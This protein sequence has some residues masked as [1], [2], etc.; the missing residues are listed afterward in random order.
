[1]ELPPTGFLEA[2]WRF[3]LSTLYIRWPSLKNEIIGTLKNEI[4]ST[5]LEITYEIGVLGLV[6]I[7]SKFGGTKICSIN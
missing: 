5:L 6:L 7:N 2:W 4:I 1:M 3:G